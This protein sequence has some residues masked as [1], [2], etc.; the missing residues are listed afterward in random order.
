MKADLF[1]VDAETPTLEVIR[2]MRERKIA[3]VPVVREGRLVGT[4]SERDF[5]R[6][7]ERLLG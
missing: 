5:L 4:V 2:E 3:C 6:V 1:T 7:V